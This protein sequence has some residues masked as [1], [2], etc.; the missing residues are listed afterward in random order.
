MISGDCG[1]ALHYIFSSC[2]VRTGDADLVRVGHLRIRIANARQVADAG[3]HVQVIEQAVIALLPFSFETRLSDRE[4]SPKTMASAGQAWAQA[5]VKESAGNASV[6]GGSA[7]AC[8][9]AAI[10]ASSMRCTQKVHFSMTPRMRTVT[11]GFFGILIVSG[12]ALFGQTARSIPY[13]C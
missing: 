7:G 5:V 3:V 6:V 9:F 11:F 1:G 13:T 4:M 2:L 8:T 10:L 12:A